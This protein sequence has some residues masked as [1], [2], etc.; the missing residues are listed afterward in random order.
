MSSH[1]SYARNGDVD[2]AYRIWGDGPH[3]IVLI[4]DWM[5]HLE[6][7]TELPDLARYLDRLSAFGRVI[8][9]DMRGAG[10]SD[11]VS[12]EETRRGERYA[13]DPPVMPP[14][15]PTRPTV[16]TMASAGRL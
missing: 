11:P 9:T 14:S 6:V 10:T 5:S 12:Y 7:I 8:M 16:A 2:L 3:D 15:S 13:N 4:L 1:I